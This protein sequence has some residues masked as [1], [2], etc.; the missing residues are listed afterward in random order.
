M[1]NKV[2]WE[3]RVKKMIDNPLAIFYFIR[4]N[5]Y[6]KFVADNYVPIYKKLNILDA[7]E[8]LNHIIDNNTSV[9]RLG[10][11]EFGLMRGA[12]VYFNDWRQKYSR[13]LRDGLIKTLSSNENNLLICLPSEH[14]RKTK[15]DLIKENKTNEF[16]FW[17]NSKVLCHKYI[18]PEKLYG[19]SFAFHP[20][21]NSNIN[22]D[23]LKSYLSAKNLII[24]T[25]NT[26]RFANIKLGKTNDFIESPKS[27]SWDKVDEIK[28]TL[29]TLVTQKGYGKKEVLVMV[30]MGSAAK[31]MV[32]DLV[33]DGYTAW[34]AG[35]FFD[36]AFK[37]ISKLST[38]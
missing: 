16:K 8:T 1:L 5:L 24:I 23:K 11:G 37:E 2:I 30:S 7:E 17:I 4:R 31:V 3:Q 27:D 15:P 6:D 28:E 38:N 35:Q 12:S 26:D 22:Y 13:D 20:L 10:D 29:N 19:S 33:V 9:V 21:F 32:Y 34:D 18:N 14:L 25:Y 36:L